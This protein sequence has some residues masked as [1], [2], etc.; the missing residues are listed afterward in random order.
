MIQRIRYII[1]IYIYLISTASSIAVTNIGKMLSLKEVVQLTEKASPELRISSQRKQEAHLSTTV[2]RSAL[3]P[4][5]DLSAADSWGY[6]GSSSPVPLEFGGLLTSPF[7]VGATAGLIGRLTI[8]DLGQWRGL[9]ES[10]ENVRIA[11]EQSEVTRIQVDQTAINL[12]FE[13][14]TYRGESEAW[15]NTIS[16]LDPILRYIKKL[17]KNGQYS[18]VQRLLLEDQLSEAELKKAVSWDHYQMSLKRLALFTGLT[19]SPIQIPPGSSLITAKIQDVA[20][21][22]ES[23]VLRRA[24]AEIRAAK[25]S[26][27]KISAQHLPKLYAAGSAGFMESSR[28]VTKQDISGWIGVTVPLFEGFRINAESERAKVIAN[29]KEDN[30]IATQLVFEDLNT[31][32]DDT[33]RSERIQLAFLAR[34]RTQATQALELTRQRYL[35]FLEPVLNLK[36]AI[37]NLTRIDTQI[38]KSSAQLLRAQANKLVLNGGSVP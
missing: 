5:L 35:A 4:K 19:D 31:Q 13:A 34:E 28:L 29:E 25:V 23:P 15:E 24:Q 17:V 2:A 26:A 36:E 12:Y 9:E 20:Q 38:N 14:A 6:P 1:V 16:R 30:L 32:Y 22:L 10:Q 21:N 37:R 3:L 8:F 7:R 33:I 18:E 11:T 27:S